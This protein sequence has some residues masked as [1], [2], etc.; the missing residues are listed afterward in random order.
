MAKRH[1][2]VVHSSLS[3][4]SGTERLFATLDALVERNTRLTLIAESGSRAVVTR[5]TDLELEYLELPHD[6]FRAPFAAWRTRSVLRRMKPSLMHFTDKGLAPL[7]AICA[8]ATGAPY[9]LEIHS[10]IVDKVPRD[11]QWL[12]CVIVPS[13]A[14]R[15]AAIN[16]GQLPRE[17]VRV[18][19]N[20]P[21]PGEFETSAPD[22]EAGPSLPRIGCAC[23]FD[24]EH[25]T[26]WFLEAAR[27]LVEAKVRAHFVL[28]GEG[29]KEIQL[30]RRVRKGGMTKHVTIG[31]PTT[32]QVG[33]TLANLDV[34][35][36]CRTPG[37]G[38]LAATALVQ[39]V[40]SILAASG[41]A[42]QI[43]DDREGGILVEPGD[44]AKLAEELT[45]LIEDPDHARKLGERGRRRAVERFAPERFAKAVRECHAMAEGLA[46]MALART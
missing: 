39:G 35:V 4:S 38:W 37:P 26:D 24:D 23:S 36:S 17:L 28:L 14:L 45:R 29:P 20:A 40:P 25:D 16:H 5:D 15:E 32:P 31:V 1:T 9:V 21:T 2:V 7:A 19:P 27:L 12:R 10:P 13:D 8:R 11:D 34:H 30:R 44:S 41:E 6:P 33:Q 43:I 42:F 46:T 22:T 3:F 18:V